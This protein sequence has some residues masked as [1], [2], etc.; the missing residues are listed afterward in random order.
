MKKMLPILFVT[1]LIDMIGIGMVIPLIPILFTDPTSPSFLLH[2]YPQGMW[3]LIAG[4]VIAVSGLMQFIAAPLLGELSD[5]FGRKRLLTL[6]VAVLAISQLL[7]GLG[8][9]ISSLA[10]VL[11]SRAIAG[12]AGANFSIAQAS[13]ADVTEPKD[14]A[15]NFGLIGAAFGVGFILGP[16]LGGLI[17][18]AFDAATPFWV[19]GAL[20]V[21]NLIFITL[22]LPETRKERG[23]SRSFTLLKGFHNIRAAFLDVDARPVYLASFLYMSGFAFYTSFVGILLVYRFAFAES[24]V[25]TFFG[26]VGVWIVITQA[27][28]LRIISKKYS[29][30]SILR[31]SLLLLAISIA[32]YPFVPNPALLYVIIPFL[33]VPQG[34]SMSNMSALI[35]KGVSPEKQGAALGINGSLMAL[36]QGVIPVVA[37]FAS[38]LVGVQIPFLVG[39]MFVVTAWSV[40]FVFKRRTK[41]AS[42]P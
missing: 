16:F 4:I 28:I 21:A 24:A 40:L 18:H 20:G 34:L 1:L 33:A 36:S 19:A 9:H 42:S 30:R 39:S 10:L 26:A 11:V 3:Y 6:G 32:I 31:Y 41:A 37:G 35:S 8:V 23:P 17:A 14:R 22:F 29:E 2:G 12:I 27:V 7:F 13:I 25:G 38:S 5:I 15:R